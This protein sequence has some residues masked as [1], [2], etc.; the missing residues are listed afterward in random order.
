MQM[1]QLDC[2]KFAAY[3]GSA[4]LK[5]GKYEEMFLSGGIVIPDEESILSCQPG[6]LFVNKCYI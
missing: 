5:I 1:K 3:K 2:F 4:E 6:R